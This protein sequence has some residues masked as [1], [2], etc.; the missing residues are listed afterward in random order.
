MD[1]LKEALYNIAHRDIPSANETIVTNARHFAALQNASGSLARVYEGLVSGI[2]GDF[3]AQD[4]RE[5][6]HY[7]GG[8]TGEVV[9][10]EVLGEI[11]GKF[12]IGK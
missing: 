1:K 8:I 12:C 9:N 4:I 6:L 5:V 3:L 2:S 11:F 7:L 10:D